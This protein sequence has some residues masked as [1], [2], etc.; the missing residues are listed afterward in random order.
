M[1]WKDGAGEGLGEGSHL[2]FA[3][4]RREFVYGI[5]LRFVLSG[6]GNRLGILR[7]FWGDRG[8]G[9]APGPGRSDLRYVQSD[10]RERALTLWVNRMVD[11]FRL[12]PDVKP[13]HFELREITLLQWSGSQ[14]GVASRLAGP[15]GTCSHAPPGPARRLAES[16]PPA[17]RSCS[18]TTRRSPV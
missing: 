6:A 1:S 15:D 12:D 8:E 16:A 9:F 7:A 14:L 11:R 13:C 3:L 2:V 18:P 17:A 5:R 4:P 10:G